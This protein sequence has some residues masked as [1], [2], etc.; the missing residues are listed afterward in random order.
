MIRSIFTRFDFKET[1]IIIITIAKNT[2]DHDD[3]LRT[4]L[5]VLSGEGGV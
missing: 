1:K 3:N 2:E 5:T 4:V